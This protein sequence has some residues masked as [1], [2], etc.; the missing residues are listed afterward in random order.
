MPLPCACLRLLAT[1]VL[2]LAAP[3][4]LRAQNQTPTPAAPKDAAPLAAHTPPVL[5]PGYRL[6]YE[7]HF[8]DAS[9]LRQFVF[10]DPAAW[11]Y[12]AD[13][14]SFA[15]ELVR[16]SKYTPAVRSP[17]NIALL[18]DRV[19]GDFILDVDLIQTGKE[20]GHRDMCLFF[21]V[22]DATHFY[23]AHIAT[24]T[25][26]HA[27]NIFIVNNEPRTRISTTTTPGVN[28]GLNVWHHVRLTRT[29]GDIAVYFDAMDKPIMTATNT[30]FQQGWIGIGS[31]DDTGKA[32]NLRIWAPNE[33]QKKQ[34]TFLQTKQ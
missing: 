31:F 13:G 16:Q 27:H 15:L 7:Q 9:A 17:F 2:S 6:V 30:T 34:C 33:P 5:L 29:G 26:D 14:H 8:D 32:D 20:Y 23:Y 4:T 18:A 24:R 10:S 25:D 19:F 22:Q 1:V 12:A 21:G 28:W 11:D 3:A